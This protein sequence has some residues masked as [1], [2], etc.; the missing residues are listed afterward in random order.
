MLPGLKGPGIAGVAGDITAPAA[1]FR[2]DGEP[3]MVKVVLAN[4][5]TPPPLPPAALPWM[6]VEP[7]IVKK[8][9]PVA[10][11]PPPW[12]PVAVPALLP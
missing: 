8:V 6:V 4:N 5:A 12:L 11:T 1:L 10:L 3:F 9:V 2:I 7:F